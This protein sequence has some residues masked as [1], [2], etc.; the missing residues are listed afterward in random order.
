MDVWMHERI[1]EGMQVRVT[2]AS[3]AFLNARMNASV[4]NKSVMSD[5]HVFTQAFNLYHKNT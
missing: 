5:K 1:H 4:R 3:Y 2:D